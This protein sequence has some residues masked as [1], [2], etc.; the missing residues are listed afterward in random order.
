MNDES[1]NL[2]LVSTNFSSADAAIFN[3]KIISVGLPSA[4]AR[5]L[6]AKFEIHITFFPF[7][8]DIFDF[9]VKVF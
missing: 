8:L 3:K 5:R 6:S 9:Q 4:A 7:N 2:I 1:M